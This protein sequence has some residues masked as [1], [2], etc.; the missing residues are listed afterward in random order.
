MKKSFKIIHASLVQQND[1]W[2]SFSVQF[3]ED[4]GK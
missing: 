3:A 4:G 1:F 2:R